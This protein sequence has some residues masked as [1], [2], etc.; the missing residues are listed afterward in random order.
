M[1]ILGL[2]KRTA[3]THLLILAAVVTAPAARSV[4]EAQTQPV[5][6][7]LLVGINIYD[8]T[9][10]GNIRNLNGPMHDVAAMAGVLEKRY[11]FNPRNV[12]ILSETS[13]SRKNILDSIQKYL[14]DAASPGDLSVFYFSGHGSERFNSLTDKP[15][16]WDQT[17]VPQDILRSTG[18][19]ATEAIRDKEL[20][21]Y[22]KKIIAK[23]VVLTAIFDSCYSGAITR[24]LSNDGV[25]RFSFKDYR[26]VRDAPAP[27][28]TV[29]E[30]G[31]ILF[32]AAQPNEEAQEPNEGNPVVGFFTSALI[33]A[34]NSLPVDA[35][36]GEVLRA[37]TQ[38][39][40]ENGQTSQ[41]PKLGGPQDRP[42]FGTVTENSGPLRLLVQKINADGT[43]ELDGGRVLGLGVGSVF[44]KRGAKN[45]SQVRLRLVNVSSLVSSMAESIVG[46]PTTVRQ[47]DVFEMIKWAP[48]VDERLRVWMPPPVAT[49]SIA[50]IT[51]ELTKLRE[52]SPMKWIV[53][54]I[55]DSP[56]YVLEWGG[57]SWLLK[58]GDAEPVILGSPLDAQEV[59]LH[60]KLA[61]PNAGIFAYLPP[62]EELWQ[63]LHKNLGPDST[64]GSVYFVPRS[65][66]QYLLVGRT[67]NGRWDYAWAL[68]NTVEDSRTGNTE[69][70]E[71]ADVLCSADSALPLRSDW[72]SLGTGLLDA[73]AQQIEERAVRIGR[74]SAIL[75]L[76]TPFGGDF[77]YKL[78]LRNRATHDLLDGG[79]THEGE[80]YEYELVAAPKDLTQPTKPRWIY[81]FTV[82]CTGRGQL[83]YPGPKEGNTS[84]LK[85]DPRESQFAMRTHIP[86]NSDAASSPF[87]FCVDKPFGRDTYFLVT[88]DEAEPIQDTTVFNFEPV[89]TRGGGAQDAQSNPLTR[90][91]AD[92]GQARS[93]SPS[94]DPVPTHWSIQKLYFQ[95]VG[96]PA[97]PCPE[98]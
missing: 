89:L 77:A 68:P 74:L 35:P 42:L 87:Y 14:L 13:A 82:D 16:H 41:H 85:P 4:S 11:G 50:Q 21:F 73:T 12:Q 27:G 34:L 51:A 62:T 66:S 76:T 79:V 97:H 7:A 26:D 58:S 2:T 18:A 22:F 55:L 33:Q 17:I 1:R 25:P 46:D 70:A 60:L 36:S 28:K 95:S 86:I 49:S 80:S 9:G 72:F 15:D 54:P 23:G 91:F 10:R 30:L 75:N 64:K 44:E 71:N 31:G 19:N 92:V 53:D 40:Q 43:F 37:V 39:L 69:P 59:I 96:D 57:S 45:E 5:K 61:D 98:P 83:L 48:P 52:T 78:R 38:Q 63:E 32:A 84:N 65:E 90:L 29:E 24:G 81:I 3:C 93:R 88:T 56:T 20:A 6:R 8:A 94:D 67:L 47:G